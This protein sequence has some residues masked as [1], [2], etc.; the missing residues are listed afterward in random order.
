MEYFTLH[1]NVA[2]LSYS[3]LTIGAILS[4]FSLLFEKNLT[5]KNKIFSNFTNNFSLLSMEKFLFKI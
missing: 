5:N 2:I 4:I 1:I 3:L